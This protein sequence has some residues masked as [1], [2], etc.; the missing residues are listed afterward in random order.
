MKFFNRQS[1]IISICPGANDP[2]EVLEKIFAQRDT[3]ARLNLLK[4][5]TEQEK[6]DIERKKMKMEAE[7]EAF[8]FESVKEGEQ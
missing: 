8:R 7:L 1:R 2:E 4:T 5:K 3:K 6:Q